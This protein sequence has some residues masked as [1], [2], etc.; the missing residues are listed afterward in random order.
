MLLR[1]LQRR[2]V[3]VFVG[4]LTLVMLLIITLVTNSNRRIVHDETARELAVGTHVFMRLLEQN[5][6]QLETAATVL[7][8]DFAFREAIATQDRATVQS[9]IRNHGLRIGA[10]AMMVI[11]P[12]GQMIADTQQTAAAARDFPFPDLLASA[13]AAERS[14]GFRQM[15]DGFLYQIVLVPIQAPRLIAWVAMGFQV[16]DRWARDLSDMLGLSVSIV[17]RQGQEV[18]LLASSLEPARRAV[19]TQALPT[20]AGDAGPVLA[21]GDEHFQTRQLPLNEDVAAVL[22]RSLEQVQAPFDTLQTALLLT[23][24]GGIVV[25]GIGSVMLARRIVRPVRELTA[26]AQRIEAGDYSQ[27]VP[28]LPADEIGQLAVSFDHMRERIASR[29]E[30]ILKLAY[31]DTLTGLANRTRFVE[32]L[33]RLLTGGRG[34]VALLNI[35]RF[36]KINSALGH[37]VGDRLLQEIGQRLRQIAPAPALVA[38]LWG[39][40]FAFLLEGAD[41]EAA[42]AFAQAVL[43][44][45]RNPMTLETQRLDVGGSLAI[46]LYPQDGRDATTLLRRAEQ[47]LAAAKRLHHGYAFA[48]DTGDEPAYEQLSLIGEMREALARGEFVLHYQPKLELAGGGIIGAEA[49]LRWRHP[50]RGLV[51]PGNFLPFAEQTGFIREITPWLLEQVAAQAAQWHRAGLPLV[52]SAN[53]SALDLLDPALVVH[54]RRLLGEQNFPPHRLCLEITES[55]LMDDPD[56]ALA[57]LNELSALG[58]KLSIDDYGSGQASLAYLKIL[59]VDELKIDRAFVTG[60]ADSPKNA[61]IVRSTILLGHELGFT[62]TAEGVE[63]ASD[64]AWLRDKGCD[65]AQGYGIARPM[66]A[67]ELPAWIRAFAARA[68]ADT[69]SSAPAA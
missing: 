65:V 58:V 57:H 59:P 11:S 63:S 37:P 44:R 16:D 40:E 34:A 67:Q 9:V 46:A 50:A 25:F 8:G 52:I 17:R 60:V 23:L 49:L 54:V 26:A 28:R 66:P 42:T 47:A 15:R 32:A 6:R 53:L 69:P 55:A 41:Q 61:A 18:A 20:L 45:L 4:L 12:D 29:E 27:P 48:A 33:D 2:I 51:T 3:L 19:L 31:E 5:Q 1:S 22:Q 43:A 10:Q 38:R 68:G 62:V 56:L 14:S 21:I 24:L 30:K 7:A 13:R 39:N 36:G 35:D 64:R